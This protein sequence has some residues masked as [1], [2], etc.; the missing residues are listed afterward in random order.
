MDK[1]D[2]FQELKN[3]PK[4]VLKDLADPRESESGS[5]ATNFSSSPLTL[6]LER[7]RSKTPTHRKYSADIMA[8]D[9]FADA[10]PFGEPDFNE[11]LFPATESTDPFDTCFADFTMFGSQ[12]SDKSGNAADVFHGPLRVSLPPEKRGSSLLPPPP[13]T[14]K[15]SSPTFK[16]SPKSPRSPLKQK[17]SVSDSPLVRIPSPQTNRRRTGAVRRSP[18]ADDERM[19]NSSV[20]LA[21]AAPEPPPRPATTKP[22]PLPPKKQLSGQQYKPPRPPPSEHYDYINNI[23]PTTGS[24]SSPPLPMPV[25]RPRTSSTEIPR[26]RQSQQQD[27][28]QFALPPPPAKEAKEIKEEKKPKVAA[29]LTLRQLTKMNITEL[30]SS[31]SVSPGHLSKMTLQELASFLGS[32]S[33]EGSPSSSKDVSVEPIKVEEPEPVE[34]ER[35][36]VFHF[37]EKLNDLYSNFSKFLA[38]KC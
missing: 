37:E 28:A 38:V 12:K 34:S 13:A 35:C 29:N 23:E 33:A 10:D 16:S 2:F 36:C 31:L 5:F 25:R 24:V 6:Q 11:E 32:V 15:R 18:L 20:E 9:P 17:P 4:K 8:L 21:D 30:A 3:P 27:S 26:P 7:E 22:P 14:S 19:S 1:K